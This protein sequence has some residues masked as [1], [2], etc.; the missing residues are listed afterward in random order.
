MRFVDLLADCEG[1]SEAELRDLIDSL[2][3]GINTKAK[4]IPDQYVDDILDAYD[5]YA[6]KKEASGGKT[7]AAPVAAK[8]VKEPTVD[9]LFAFK[10]KGKEKEPEVEAPSFAD[11]TVISSS[12]STGSS[13]SAMEKFQKKAAAGAAKKAEQEKKKAKAKKR[14]EETILSPKDSGPKTNL[15]NVRTDDFEL[16]IEDDVVTDDM[17]G[18]DDNIMSAA[19]RVEKEQ[20]RQLLK[21]QR[22]KR[23]ANIQSNKVS[24]EELEKREAQRRGEHLKQ[25]NE[26]TIGE[27]ITVKE[28]AEKMGI[29]PGNV[30]KA[31]IKNG[32]IVTINHTIDFDTAALIGE[33]LKV[34]VKK[35][36]TT[37]SSSDLAQGNLQ[38]LLEQED[39][40]DQVDR[41]PIISIM[42]HVDHGKTSLLDFIR[43]SQITSG[44]AG[45]ITQQIGA[46]QVE[47]KGK[48]I[49]FLDTPGH[50]AF[51]AMRA[52]GAKSTDIAILVVAADEG[53]KPQTEEALNH[54]KDAGIPII[55][56]INKIDKEGA[57]IE[58]VKTQLTELELIPEEWGGSTVMAP[59]SAKT[60]DGIPELLDMILLVSEM[61]ELKADP[62]RD[63]LGTVIESHLDQSLGPVATILVNTGTLHQGDNFV[64]GETFGRVKTMHN[65]KMKKVET[66]LPSTP[67]RISGL[68]TAPHVGDILQVLPTEKEARDKAIELRALRSKTASKGTALSE[69]IN[70]INKGELK[71]LKVVLKADTKGTLEAVRSSVLKLNTDEVGVGNVTETDVLMAS[72]AG[73]IVLGFA[74]DVPP[75]T[76]RAAEKDN[77]TIK[78]Y[79]VIYH[80]TDEIKKLLSGLLDPEIREVV[81]GDF[82]VI[83]PFYSSRKFMI[84]GGKVTKGKIINKGKVRV[85]RGDKLV[86]EGTIDSLQKG[87][88]SVNEIS[89]GHECGIKFYG[90]CVPEAKDI[91]EVYTVE[92][93]ERSL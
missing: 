88:E 11:A 59:I 57:N 6:E 36:A 52:R 7:E 69:L 12:P 70:K 20:E 86:G 28:F 63:A 16:D 67:V 5:D 83:Q 15:S 33:E 17:D 92:K 14:K 84:L 31:L 35:E 72:A 13:E 51:T 91:L 71:Q 54:A 41:P 79:R 27:T 77:V 37:F 42:G 58:R 82:E 29:A 43:E 4:I 9:D 40:A 3:L 25:K 22:E 53:V 64:V 48:K 65:S 56:A 34:T 21:A 8:K 49:T 80:L 90:K 75:Q 66:G 61:G 76:M 10:K 55:V 44:E 47:V 18:E 46:Y 78:T 30:V 87:K 24:S 62:S 85:I 68:D 19:E 23:A 60:G 73:G 39:K 32:V 26:I 93:I 1:A 45:G 50:E 38:A 74:V 89:E 2:E 81:H